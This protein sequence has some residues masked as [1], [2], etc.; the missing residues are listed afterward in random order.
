ML[1]ILYLKLILGSVIGLAIGMVAKNKAIKDKSGLANVQYSGIGEL[2]KEEQKRIWGT[3]LTIS[4][5]F[6]IVGQGIDPDNLSN[7]NGKVKFLWGI[8]STTQRIIWEAV[9]VTIFSTVGYVGIDIALKYFGATSQR[10][11]RAID[12]KTTDADRVNGT[13]DKPT[14]AV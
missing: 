1:I 13:L 6:L 7:P 2:I 5:A 10:I 9:L 11:N 14:P 4:L 3:L 12:S 8:F